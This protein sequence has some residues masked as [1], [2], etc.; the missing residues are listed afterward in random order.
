MFQLW[1]VKRKAYALEPSADPELKWVQYYYDKD[2][3]VDIAADLT[4]STNEMHLVHHMSWTQRERERLRVGEYRKVAW[5]KHEFWRFRSDE[6]CRHFTH[7]SQKNPELIAYTVDETKGKLDI[8]TP[9]KPGAYLQRFFPELSQQ[10]IKN[11]CELHRTYISETD[12]SNYELKLATTPEEIVEVYNNGPESCMHGDRSVRVYG[13]GDLAIAHYESNDS[14]R[15]RALCWPSKKVYGRVYPGECDGGREHH[16]L[17]KLLDAAG[18]RKGDGRSFNGAKLKKIDSIHGGWVMPYLD[19]SYGVDDHGDHFVMSNN[20]DHDCQETSGYI[21][22]RER[23]Y[24]DRCEDNCDEINEVRISRYNIRSW[25][26][27]CA[28]EYAFYCNHT[29]NLVCLDSGQEVDGE[30]VADWVEVNFC[31][32]DDCATTNY[33]VEVI[34]NLDGDTQMWQESYIRDET[35]TCKVTG[36]VYKL[37][38]ASKETLEKVYDMRSYP[39]W[40]HEPP[41]HTFKGWRGVFK[42]VDAGQEEYVSTDP[43]Q[44]V[45]FDDVGGNRFA[46]APTRLALNE[47]IRE[48]GA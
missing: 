25:C 22:G 1:N 10:E 13:A 46:Y 44:D 47:I 11:L 17:V 9:M 45:L 30:T 43:D 28:N 19:W 3:A 48:L 16:I 33:V 7:V 21:Q 8:Q 32:H 4:A 12:A 42:G 41:L 35:F 38:L 5:D 39:T 29:N 40:M 18:Y 36:L 24:C 26:G 14:V 20:P 31:E 6:L 27:H 23:Y 2:T 34:V 15:A 37:E